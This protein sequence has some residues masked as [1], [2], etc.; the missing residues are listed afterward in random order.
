MLGTIFKKKN[1]KMGVNILE[2]KTGDICYYNQSKEPYKVT[3]TGVTPRG[4]FY[5]EI[6][7]LKSGKSHIFTDN[8]TV[9]VDTFLTK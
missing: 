8:Y 2:L 7:H 1:Q 9:W 4:V 6:Q 3:E 5:V